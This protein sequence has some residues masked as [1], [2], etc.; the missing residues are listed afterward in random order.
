MKLKETEKLEF[1]KSTKLLKEASVSISAILNKHGQGEIYFGLADNGTPVKNDISANTIRTVTQAISDKIEPKIFPEIEVVEIDGTEVIKVSFTGYQPPY[2]AE[3]R[4]YIRVGDEDRKLSASELSSLII[5]HKDLRWDSGI[6]KNADIKEIDTAKVKKFCASSGIMFTSSKDILQN[7]S[8]IKNDKLLNA[9]LL[10]YAKN[11]E[12]IFSNSKLQCAVFTGISTSAIIDQ[13]VF[14]GD[15]I[16]LIE[17]AE[18]YIL[19]NIHFG[20]LVDG[21]YRKDIP[22]TNTE[23]IR[24]SVV[25]AFI[26]RD[27][28]DPD[29]ISIHIFKDRI[30][31]RNPGGLFGGLTIKDI[32]TRYISKRRNELLADVLNRAHLVERKGRGIALILEKEPASKFEQFGSV[33]ISTL[34][35]NNY[36]IDEGLVDRLVEKLGEN[37]A[38]IVK[39]I[40]ENQ[41]ISKKELSEYL[42]I[43]TT[44]VDKNLKKLKE[45][46]IIERIGPDRGGYWTIIEK[47]SQG[48]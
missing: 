10:L 41:R 1:K 16:Y 27:Y 46:G 4:Y 34:A 17:E 9:A 14:A 11:P 48:R 38:L 12:K 25:N 8:L 42:K 30:E 33:F 40:Y 22:E 32:T 23:A 43:S 44:A 18:K 19:K 35:R 24:E 7:L 15:I 29:F 31:I 6:C 28:F 37:Q 26:H 2:S 5:N 21:L 20:M 3:G 36:T 13:K 47:P 39:K 45:K